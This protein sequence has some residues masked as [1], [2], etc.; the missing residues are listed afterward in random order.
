[1]KGLRRGSQEVSEGL[2]VPSSMPMFPLNTYGE[3]NISAN[4]R[5]VAE[6][7]HAGLFL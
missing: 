5:T 2:N 6:H 7:S 4:G 1:M 3:A